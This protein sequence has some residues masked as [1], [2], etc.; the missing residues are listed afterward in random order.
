M[1][2]TG[3]KI[4]DLNIKQIVKTIGKILSILSIVFIGVKIYQLGFD[5]KVIENVPAFIAISV[6]AVLMKMFS[7]V[8]SASGWRRWISL[9]SGRKIRFWDAFYIY[10]KAGI[11][12]YL[13]GNVMHYVERNIFA[14]EYGLPQTKIAAGSVLETLELVIAALFMSLIL[15]PISYRQKVLK[16]I[17]ERKTILIILILI[18]FFIF[19]AIF[20]IVL[21]KRRYIKGI[22]SEY[23]FSG[24][25]TFALTLIEYILTLL[26]LGGGMVLM[27]MFCT[28][29]SPDAESLRLMISA[30]STAWVC[31]FVIPGASGGIGIREAILSVLLDGLASGSVTMFVIVTHRLITIIGDFATYAVVTS[32][33]SFSSK[34][35]E[36]K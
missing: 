25:K 1:K 18:C 11:G 30:Y 10:G 2:K 29:E 8:T 9:F 7:V 12:K 16:L 27:W 20:A 23:K 21:I 15:L 5:P 33:F 19:V 17:Y 3:S 24:L 35:K 26:L 13:P 32:I 6:I 31:G 36:S 34:R 28:Q 14:A 4:T 22:I